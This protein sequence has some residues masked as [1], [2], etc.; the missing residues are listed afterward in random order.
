[1]PAVKVIVIGSGD[2]GQHIARTLSAERHDVTVV[3]MDPARV[4]SLQADLDA[5][6]VPGNGASPKVLRRLGVDEA[7]LVCAVTDNDE[8]NVIAA[9]A[10][11]QLGAGTTVARVR[12]DDYFEG[13]ASS[14]R[15]VL[16]IDFVIH[17]ERATAA[18]LAESILLPGSV[19]VEYFAGGRLAVTESVVDARST[20]LGRPLGE[21]RMMR[22]NF[23]FG[24]IRDGKAIAAEPY[25]KVQAGDHV[26]A[27]AAREDI[28][29]VAA[30]IAG[31]TVRVR[32]VMIFGAGRVGLPLA[33]KLEK[34]DLRVSL[35]ERDADRARFVA[36]H[37]HRATVLH[38]EGVSKEAMLAHGVDRVGAFVACAGDDRANLLAALHA[39]QLGAGLNLAVVSREE[40]TPLVDA[41][42]VDAAFSPR[43]VTAEAILRTVRGANV[44]AIHLMLGGG[45]IL[46]VEA[47]PDCSADG[48]TL[49][50]A[51]AMVKARIVAIVRGERVIMPLPDAR[52]R[53]G[54]HVIV[55]N[56]RAGVA[57]VKRGFHAA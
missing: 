9:M 3:D 10:A 1:M 48:R 26:L 2:V 25:H 45:E 4:E 8:A 49:E 46:E 51:A 41:L 37:V 23:I 55:F 34:T 47:E 24:I 5:L 19:H 52:V 28:R 57:D 7:D 6:V 12:D 18:D 13:D 20:L 39:K 16:G 32:E 21:R 15:D 53:A 42:G 54:D 44:A 17:P 35:M 33:R 40:F 56:P 38:E 30:Q 11:H 29:E 36:E 27:A 31:R 50:A 14:G 43:L 22:P